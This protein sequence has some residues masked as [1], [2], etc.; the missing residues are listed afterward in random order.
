MAVN[1]AQ[2]KIYKSFTRH[3]VPDDLHSCS[4]SSVERRQSVQTNGHGLMHRF[5]SNKS[6]EPYNVK[7]IEGEDVV[8]LIRYDSSR[9]CSTNNKRNVRKAPVRSTSLPERTAEDQRN[10][11]LMFCSMSDSYF[12]RLRTTLGSFHDLQFLLAIKC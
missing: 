1:K 11:A 4:R 12:T 10:E 5:E 9:F 8:G 7:D 3:H 6:Q 2:A